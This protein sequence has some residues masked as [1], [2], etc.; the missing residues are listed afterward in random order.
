MF[1]QTGTGKSTLLAQLMRQDVAQGVGFCLIDPHGDL[2]H[3]VASVAADKAIYWDA[4]DPDGRYGYNPLTFVSKQYRPLVA[5]GV[6][7][8]LKKQW[9]DA[10]GARM[11]HL[12]RYA[13]LALLERPRSSLLDIVP[14]FLDKTF[15]T[16]VLQGVSDPQVRQFW[17]MEYKAMNLK[18][19]VDGVAPIANKLGAFLAHPVIRKAVCT[20]EQPLRFRQ[21]MDKG[22]ILIVNLAKGRLGADV[23]NVLGGLVVSS[24]AQAAL[25]RASVSEIERRPYFLYLD[26]FQNLT[27]ESVADMLSELRKYR[28]GLVLATQYSSRLQESVREAI[29]GNVGSLI[30][31]RVGANDAT[32]IAKQFGTKLPETTDL[33]NLPNYD[34]YVKLMIDGSQSKPF[35]ARTLPPRDENL[36][37]M[38]AEPPV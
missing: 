21:L 33:V 18:T 17:E 9:A 29:F 14:M 35:S 8:A 1:G 20:P 2:A 3:Q 27:T 32:L 28:L 19:A 22:T 13:L 31:F 36:W 37:E 5:S 11:E 15:R 16:Q 24:L 30:S 25:S 38:G 10:W 26:E 4:A 7:E 6:I 34:M 12:L 23:S